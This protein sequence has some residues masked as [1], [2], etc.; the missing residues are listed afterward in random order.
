MRYWYIEKKRYTVVA[1]S[2]VSASWRDGVLEYE[3][4]ESMKIC[5]R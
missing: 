3:S 5:K 1:M 2:S 4:Y